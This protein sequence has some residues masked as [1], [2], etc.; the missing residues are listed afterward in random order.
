VTVATLPPPSKLNAGA[1]SYASET[2]ATE[3]EVTF[4]RTMSI[5]AMLVDRKYYPTLRKFYTDVLLADQ[6]PVLLGQGR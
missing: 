1:L 4:Q 6:K 2:T 5:D 3:T